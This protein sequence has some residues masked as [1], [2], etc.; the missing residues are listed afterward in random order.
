LPEKN[1]DAVTPRRKLPAMPKIPTSI[2]AVVSEALANRYSHAE[3]NLMMETAGLELN[4]LPGGNRQVKTRAWFN[5]ANKT[6]PDPLATLGKVVAEFMEKDSDEWDKQLHPDQERVSKALGR[7]GLSYMRGGYITALGATKVSKTLQDIIRA[8]DLSGL[9]TEFDRIYENL[10]A[11]PPAAVTASC[12]LLESLFKTY[13]EDNKLD[14]PSE[15]SI[16]PLWKVVRKDLKLDPAIVN[17]DDLKTILTGLAAIVEGTGSLRT[18]KGSAH[19]HGKTTNYK[20]KPRHARL[21]AH[22]A[23]TLANYVLEAWGERG[24]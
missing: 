9:Q 5:H 15:E 1:G 10:E 7:Y 16:K 23:S 2:I 13:I 3:I 4:P 20:L 22:A 18:H 12:A 24:A 11:D 8:R 19:G 6:S 14:M 17:D 21:A